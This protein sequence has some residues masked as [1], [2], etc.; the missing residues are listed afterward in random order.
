MHQH[1]CNI[2]LF[3]KFASMHQFYA[4]MHINIYQLKQALTVTILTSEYQIL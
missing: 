2:L 4:G 3:D 1:V